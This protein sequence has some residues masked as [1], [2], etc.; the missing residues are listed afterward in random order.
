MPPTINTGTILA[1]EMRGPGDMEAAMYRLQGEARP[2]LLAAMDAAL[3]AVSLCGFRRT[4]PA[5]I[6]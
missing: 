2:R 5:V 6:S 1:K 3:Q 4:N